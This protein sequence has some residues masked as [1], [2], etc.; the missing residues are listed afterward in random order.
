HSSIARDDSAEAALL[1][2][3]RGGR[4]LEDDGINRVVLIDELFLRLEIVAAVALVDK[5]NVIG[6]DLINH[7]QLE[8]I[9]LLQK[10]SE[11]RRRAAAALRP[12]LDEGC[13]IRA[14]IAVKVAANQSGADARAVLPSQRL[15]YLLRHRHIA[16]IGKLRIQHGL[17][18]WRQ[19]KR[20][21][22]LPDDYRD[23]AQPQ[24]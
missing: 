17:R 10:D 2:N 3:V 4:L 1:V 20:G 5:L 15:L 21:G 8:T 23:T 9:L 12:M 22:L 18:L 11:A 7:V 14:P 6:V 19:S 13:I 16:P 24:K